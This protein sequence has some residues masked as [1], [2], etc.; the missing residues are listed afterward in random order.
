[1]CGRTVCISPLDV[2]TQEFNISSVAFEPSPN[3]NISPSQSIPVVIN[4]NGS[5]KLISCRWGFIPSWS[6]DET[7]G[8]KMINARAETIAEKSSF[9]KA[10]AS[11]RC[12]VI[13]D[14]FY[15][16]SQKD[17]IKTPVYV[18]MKSGKP[19]GFAGLY[20]VW[21]S[22]ENKQICTSTIITTQA[23]EL[24]KPIH[25]RM[26]VILPKDIEKQWLDPNIH[27]AS[28]VL[29]LLKPYSS[30]GLEFYNVS[31]KV[32]SPKNN[33]PECIRPIS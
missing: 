2:I 17:K 26:P 15:E 13:A 11:Q 27:D 1:M 3:Y 24:L 7:I 31:T 20:N 12:L 16:W 14:G 4:E 33:S 23:N 30:E 32:N 28:A 6:K 25:D 10:F 5:N 22:P 19:F 9:K 18:H 21:T 29:P 8:H